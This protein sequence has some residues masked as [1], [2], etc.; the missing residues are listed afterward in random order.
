MRSCWMLQ[1]T[2]FH[3]CKQNLLFLMNCVADLIWRSFYLRRSSIGKLTSSVPWLVPRLDWD[4]IEVRIFCMLVIG[5]NMISW[6]YAY[7]EHIE[8]KTK[9]V[10]IIHLNPSSATFNNCLWIIFSQ[11]TSNLAGYL[12]IKAFV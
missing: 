6:F 12:F 5:K 11:D 7:V 4:R 1:T 8:I 9:T 3:I 2:G 10:N